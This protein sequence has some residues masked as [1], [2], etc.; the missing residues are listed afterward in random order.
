MGVTIHFDGQLLGDD[1]FRGLITAATT[2][3][4]TY[5]WPIEPIESEHVT[6]SRV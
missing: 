1:A 2:Y 6:L 4:A 3:A 5:G